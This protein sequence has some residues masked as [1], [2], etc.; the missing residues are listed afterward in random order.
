MDYITEYYNNYDEDGRLNSRK[1]EYLTTMRY[2]QKYLK[3]DCKILEI[4]AATGRYSIALAD[5]G[6]DVTSVEFVESNLDILKSKIKA[7]HNI[8][9]IQG[10]ARNLNFIESDV[11]DIVLL[12]GPMYHLY[13]DE[14]KHNAISEAVRVC[15]AGGIIFA[16]YCNN[17]TTMHQLFVQH[18]LSDYLDCIDN[19]FHAISKPELVFELYRKED[20][21]RIM[22]GF[23]VYRLHYVGADMLS[24]CFDEAFDEMTDEEFNLYMKYHYAICEREDM[25]GLSFHMLDIF[26]KE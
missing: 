9:A 20:V 7:N 1:P 21:D 12:L 18:K 15:K 8:T 5:M 23:D 25:I 6:F 17:D 10:D 24:N 11:Y 2:I 22:S 26:R 3:P 13:N 14:D 16:A 19:Q 4:G